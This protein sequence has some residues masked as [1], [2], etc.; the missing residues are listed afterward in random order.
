MDAHAY[1]ECPDFQELHSHLRDDGG[2]GNKSHAERGKVRRKIRAGIILLDHRLYTH[3][4]QLCIPTSA[5]QALLHEFHDSDLAGHRGPSQT[6]AM[7]QS[8]FYW[9][10]MAAAVHDFCG[11]C[12]KCAQAKART[13]RPWTALQPNMPP[14]KP[15]THY[16]LD[17]IFGLPK[18]G[19]L[20]HDGILVAVDQF[21]NHVTA[22]PV[23]EA[24]PA[25]AAAE[26]FYRE[27]VCRRGVRW[28]QTKALSGPS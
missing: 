14:I 27:I 4:G 7:L 22:L 12:S 18:A 3:E 8:R 24:A 28:Q 19:P 23:H 10:C 5:R 25:E 1:A 17:F 11:E 21:S 16:S 9:P 15:F 6:L 13:S 2:E 20:Q 26:T